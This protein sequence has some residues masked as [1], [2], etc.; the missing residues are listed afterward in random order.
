VSGVLI[1]RNRQRDVR[2]N[3]RLLRQVAE[4][5]LMELGWDAD[6]CL[7]I[8]LVSAAKMARLNR[9]FLRHDGPTDVITFG[10][11][12]PTAA[13]RKNTA[14]GGRPADPVDLERPLHGEV[15]I[16]MSEALAQARQFQ[17]TW[18]SELIRYIIHGV[19]H[20][21]GHDDL[22]PGARRRM[23]QAENRLLR[24]LSARIDVKKVARP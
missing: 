19:L 16:C 4:A 20:L 5:A 9:T 2:V 17:S 3:L 24:R 13:P 8:Y 21:Q 22:K 14:F 1:L 11:E 6:A 10:Y 12:T 18:P 7:G 23:K 15:F